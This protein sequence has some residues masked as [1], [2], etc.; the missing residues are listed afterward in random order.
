M[1]DWS[2]FT[3]STG[4]RRKDESDEYPVPKSSI[5]RPTPAERSCS[6][7]SA[8]AAGLS[9]SKLSV[10][11]RVSDPS[12]SFSPFSAFRTHGTSRGSRS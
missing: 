6:R 9:M 5:A 4:K 8:A 1:K 12:D 2:I 3:R 7:S 11:S 10:S